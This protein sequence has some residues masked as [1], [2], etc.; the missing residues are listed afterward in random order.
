MESPRPMK[1]LSHV[2]VRVV[3][4]VLFLG[5]GVGAL[6]GLGSL[7]Q[8]PEKVAAAEPVYAARGL[9]VEPADVQVSLS[10]YGTARPWRR[11]QISAQVGGRVLELPAGVE[12]GRVVRAGETLL[13]IDPSDFQ[14]SHDRSAGELASLQARLEQLR[15]QQANDG[16]RLKVVTRGLELAR[17][18]FDRIR[19]LAEEQIVAPAQRDQAESALQRQQ[20]QVV[21]I[22]SALALYPS[23]IRQAE[24]QLDAAGAQHERAG[25]DLERVN[26]VAPL[27]GR[28]VEKRVEQG[29][30]VTPATPLLTLADDSRLEV[31]VSLPGP[32]VASWLGLPA[33]SADPHWFAGLPEREVELRWTEQPERVWRGR[34]DRVERYNPIDRTLELVIT[35]DGP[36]AEA[37]SFPLVEGMFVEVRI[38]G[39]MLSSIYRLPRGAVG[40][41]DTVL[42]VEDG[43]LI[44]RSVRVARLQAEEALVEAGLEPGQV[45]L[46]SRPGSII[47]GMR[48]DVEL[49][50]ADGP[51]R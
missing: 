51:A 50:P 16:E 27:T 40:H 12:V 13:R 41:D 30:V 19:Q 33:E 7:R 18:E 20:E 11:V 4:V 25:L 23:Q 1:V 44:T 36:A 37:G 8:P 21:M 5:L 14:A 46:L 38:P 17:A 24:A 42:T 10:G 9:V 39:R 48:V 49:A 45:V 3:L 35:V 28:V 31:P 22:Q 32:E 6:F 34:I 29:Q 2:L 26:V 43:R 47:E 15:Q